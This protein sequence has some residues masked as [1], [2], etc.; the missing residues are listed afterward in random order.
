MNDLND[1]LTRQADRFVTDGG[2]NLDL[3]QVL[4]RA[5]EIRRGRRLRA[6]LVMAAV[7]LAVAVP[8]GIT[9]L[10]GNDDSSD[11]T[12]PTTQGPSV[13]PSP[14]PTA[15]KAPARTISALSRIPLGAKPDH[16]YVELG[17]IHD[18]DG[19]TTQ[20][21]AAASDRLAG[22]TPY[23]GGYLVANGDT[24]TVTLYDGSG[25]VVKS[26]P[27]SSYFVTTSDGVETAYVMDGKLYSNSGSGMGNGDGAV[28]PVPAGAS[29]IGYLPGDLLLYETGKATAAGAPELA[30]TSGDLGHDLDSLSTVKATDDINDRVG[31]IAHGRGTVF[32]LTTHRAVWSSPDW[33]PVAFSN[34]GRFVAAVNLSDDDPRKIAI[35]DADNG[36]PVASADL[37]A[38]DVEV[39]AG[40]VFDDSGNLL[41]VALEASGKEAILRLSPDNRLDRA[42]S[43][44][45][46]LQSDNETPLVIPAGPQ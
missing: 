44:V 1:A 11:P 46:G 33:E 42:T 41:V 39:N 13:P 30:L 8:V 35:L 4:A 45:G 21:P 5:G 32:S 17:I 43:I 15:T 7:V 3:D 25:K 19:T 26:G 28:G 6:S 10:L 9:N 2:T 34:D 24:S 12:A 20:L 38:K 31:G 16:S 37:G 29:P 18:V 22:I 36:R 14:S 40:P 23:L 27:G